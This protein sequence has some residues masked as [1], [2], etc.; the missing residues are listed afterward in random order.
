GGGGGGGGGGGMAGLAAH[1]RIEADAQRLGTFFSRTQPEGAET[2]ASGGL[3]SLPIGA[4]IEVVKQG[5]NTLDAVIALGPRIRPLL[6]LFRTERTF[7]S[8]E[9]HF[10][11]LAV[12]AAMTGPLQPHC[13]GISALALSAHAGA[14]PQLDE[15]L[16]AR[17]QTARPKGDD[18]LAQ[19]WD[20]AC[21]A[22]DQLRAAVAGR[23][24]PDSDPAVAE[25]GQAE[26]PPGSIP[27]AP[28][29]TK[30]VAE[31]LHR[32]AHLA[33]ALADNAWPLVIEPLS[34]ELV[35]EEERSWR[36]WFS[37]ETSRHHCRVACAMLLFNPQLNVLCADIFE[38]GQTR[39]STLTTATYAGR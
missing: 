38:G 25:P 9:F 15:A 29:E 27:D 37:G 4:A 2:G 33:A 17:G 7:R 35:H 14:F 1:R 26:G 19:D 32:G 10:D 39:D 23:M 36:S 24:R 6:Q 5:L 3:E 8:E 11:R 12:L 18:R 20:Q 34:V 30:A 21:D 16:R 13:A 22:L 31:S 28:G